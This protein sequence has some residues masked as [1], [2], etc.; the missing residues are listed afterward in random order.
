MNN[1]YIL[2]MA[3]GEGTR[4]APLSTPDRPKQFLSFLGE[5]SFLQQT[6]R[7]VAGV[8]PAERI[9]V[10]TNERYEEMVRAQLPDLPVDNIVGEPEKKNTAP[11]I[12]Y[13]AR[14]IEERDPHAVMVVLPSDHVILHQERFEAV[15]RY[16]VRVARERDRLVT[17]GI[18]PDWPSSDYGYIRSKGCFVPGEIVAFDVDAF[19][20][21]PDLATARRYVDAGDYYW[22]SGMFLW[23]VERIGAEVAANLPQM[24]RS[25]AQFEAGSGFRRRFFSEVQAVSIDYGILEK[26]RNVLVIPC[27]LGWSDV[28]TWEGL[29]RL[30]RSAEMAIAP[31]VMKVMRQE[32][33]HTAPREEVGLPRRV[34]KPWGYE[35]VWAHTDQYVGK[36]L[37]IRKPHRL[38]LQYHRVKDETV[39]VVQ[40]V[41]ELEFEHDRDRRKV[42]MGEGDVFHIPA[43]ARHRMTAVEDCLVAEVSTPY[44]A[45]IVRLQDDYQRG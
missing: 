25:L 21:K 11:C 38:S 10:A 31:A 41:M 27:D 44:L 3:G 2:I 17:L 29:Y 45:D 9:L 4:F 26:S 24:H 40:G 34:E 16:G 15:V 23:T 42:R 22:N 39:R 6:C 37:F 8:V 19:V 32:L 12:A 33:G 18:R 28:G 13:A 7:R 20:E 43:G 14:L 35:E 5:G 30:S 36:M 1:V